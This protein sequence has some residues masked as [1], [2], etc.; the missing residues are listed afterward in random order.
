MA[1]PL[2]PVT[3]ASKRSN[4][5]AWYDRCSFLAEPH[6]ER[7]AGPA[8]FPVEDVPF[9]LVLLRRKFGLGQDGLREA[10][11]HLYDRISLGGADRPADCARR[12]GESDLLEGRIHLVETEGTEPSAV[13]GQRRIDEHFFRQFFKRGAAPEPF[14]QRI[15]GLPGGGIQVAGRHGRVDPDEHVL[16]VLLRY[17]ERVVHGAMDPG[18]YEELAARAFLHEKVGRFS[19][20]SAFERIVGHEFHGDQSFQIRGPLTRFVRQ[21]G[22]EQEIHIARPVFLGVNRFARHDGDRLAFRGPAAGGQQD[23]GANRY[24]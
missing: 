8:P 24:E 23:R 20:E 15:G 5:G 22:G 16:E 1:Y 6:G 12:N 10:V 13:A 14:V 11:L 3:C 21:A 4:A 18:V 9:H 2:S 17:R 7:C 19:R